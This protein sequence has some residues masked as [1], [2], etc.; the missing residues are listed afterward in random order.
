M[1]ELFSLEGIQKKPAIFDITKLEWMNGQYLSAL[2]A[3][4][5]LPAVRRE[6]DRRGIESDQDL[7]PIIDVVKIR[8][9]T[10]LDIADQ[11]ETRLSAEPPTIDQKAEQF[12]RKQGEQ[13]V[14][15]GLIFSLSALE[16]LSEGNWTSQ[17]TLNAINQVVVTTDLKLGDV[18][19]PIRIAVTGSTVSEPVNELL[20]VVG[21]AN[22]LKKIKE[23]LNKV[24]GSGN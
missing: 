14:S 8:S 13:K 17:S 6:L 12:L 16:Q 21:R 11:V 10:V 4:E 2:P 22:S 5:L 24:S 23:L 7:R 20:E 1:I 15:K 18:M 9:R 3:D 19:Q